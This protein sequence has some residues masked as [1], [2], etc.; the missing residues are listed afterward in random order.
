M[1]HS[2]ACMQHADTFE[3]VS[4]GV[5]HLANQMGFYLHGRAAYAEAESLL[6]RALEGREQV[7]GPAH[8]STL[9]SVNNLG[10]LL[11]SK[12]DFDGAEPLYRRALEGR[13]QALGPAHPDTLLSMT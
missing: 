6:R 7:L 4:A 13:E 1:P 10:G 2:A 5:A 12:G 11:D 3:V 9:V 8:P